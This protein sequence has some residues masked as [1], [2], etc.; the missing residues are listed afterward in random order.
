[1]QRE[2]TEK[3]DLAEKGR[4]GQEL[5][6]RLF[7]QL[8]AFTGCRDTA[9]LRDALASQ[10]DLTATLYEDAHDP[11]GVALLVQSEDPAF[12]VGPLRDLLDAEPWTGLTP[13]PE[14]T[15]FGRTY[16]LG[17]EPDLEET[18]LKRPRR[19][20]L[21]PDWPWAIWYPLRRSGEFMQ[22]PDDEQREILMEHGKIGF[23]FGRA[24]YAHD[25]RLACHGL[26][27]HDNDFV[28]GIIGKDLHP[29]SA[30]VQ[31]MRSTTQTALYLENLGPFFVGKVAYQS[32]E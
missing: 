15:L 32:P 7:M 2:A 22:L 13:K 9:P 26:D 16:S 18:L 17:Y 27:R 29:L 20:A 31:A 24:D 1:M 10:G 28:V 14:L 12:F 11:Q 8:L 5:D 23:A 30:V 25:I 21:N 4:G 3:P 19:T 6:R